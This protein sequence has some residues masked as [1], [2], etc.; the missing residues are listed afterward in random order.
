MS[1]DRPSIQ[2]LYR[3]HA[4]YVWRSLRYLGVADRD[5]EDQ[6]QE[7]FI[8]AARSLDSFEGRSSLRTWVYGIALRVASD[9]RRLA[10]VRREVPVAEVADDRPVAGSYADC[11]EARQL[12]LRALA[13]LEPDK[14]EVFVL[15][16]IEELEMKEI[17]ELLDMPLF[18][19][20]SRLR[21][22]RKQVRELCGEADDE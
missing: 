11:V 17:S 8:R 9:Y 7:V 19:G 4:A 5:L 12:L 1:S 10:R 3:E 18:T 14:R 21:A 6:V 2:E 16:E 20:Y 22:A 13:R 15:Y